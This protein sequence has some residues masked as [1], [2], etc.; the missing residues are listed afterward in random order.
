MRKIIFQWL[1]REF[2]S[3]S[4]EGKVSD[5]KF[6][7]SLSRREVGNN[8]RCNSKKRPLRYPTV[9]PSIFLGTVSLS[10][11]RTASGVEQP[12]WRVQYPIPTCYVN[13]SEERRVG[14][15]CRSR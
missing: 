7:L 3:L 6:L 11:H 2:V 5:R 8:P 15:E 10:N 12:F 13:R 1:E 14:K 4:S 9:A